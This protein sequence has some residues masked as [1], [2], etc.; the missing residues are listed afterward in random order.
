MDLLTY[1]AAKAEAEKQRLLAETYK[2]EVDDLKQQ[3]QKL[4]QQMERAA[5]CGMT[6][7]KYL[8]MREHEERERA[9]L[10]QETEYG[11]RM[12]LQKS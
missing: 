8:R 2:A 7:D 9:F 4:Q 11:R 6:M 12:R 1:S 10:Q 3:L 5:A